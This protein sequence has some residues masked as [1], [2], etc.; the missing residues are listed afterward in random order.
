MSRI[1]IV[2]LTTLPPSMNRLSRQ[3]GSL[4]ISQ[5]S[6]P[7]RPLLFAFSGRVFRFSGMFVF[8]PKRFKKKSELEMNTEK[9]N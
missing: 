2:G 3:C 4:D 8:G 5:P 9:R 6:R 7:P 1:V